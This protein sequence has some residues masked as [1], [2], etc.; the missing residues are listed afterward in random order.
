ASRLALALHHHVRPAQRRGRLARLEPVP[1]A[2]PYLLAHDQA[3]APHDLLLEQRDHQRVAFVADAGRFAHLPPDGDALDLDVLARELLR[4]PLLAGVHQLAHAYH[5]LA[6]A[7][8]DLELLLERRN[9]VRRARVPRPARKLVE[10]E[11]QAV[12]AAVR[13]E[14]RRRHVQHLAIGQHQGGLPASRARRAAQARLAPARVAYD[15]CHARYP[16]EGRDWRTAAKRSSRRRRARGNCRCPGAG[17]GR[18]YLIDYPEAAPRAT[19]SARERVA[20]GGEHQREQR[21]VAFGVHPL[22]RESQAARRGAHDLGL[23]AVVA[24]GAVGGQPDRDLERPA[25]RQALAARAHEGAVQTDV[26]G[27][28]TIVAVVVVNDGV[29][30]DGN[31]RGIAAL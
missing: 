12:M 15:A 3:L 30:R 8:A 13:L 4:Q 6:L 14:P 7:L 21:R 5:F 25:P 22:E 24:H 18:D 17:A 27:G 23:E 2:D 29:E 9:G 20:L 16:W 19:R 31:A 1:L 10:R 11:R 26:G 28:V